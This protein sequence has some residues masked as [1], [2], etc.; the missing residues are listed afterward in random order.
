MIQRHNRR[1]LACF[2]RSLK[3]SLSLSV[4]AG[5]AS[6]AGAKPAAGAAAATGEASIQLIRFGDLKPEGTKL[7]TCWDALGIDDRQRVYVAFSDQNDQAPDDTVI[8]RYDSRSGARELLGTLRQVSRSE[9]NLREGETIAKSHV[10][11]R[12]YN[13]KL[14]F[15]SHDYHSYKD[16][17]NIL[18]RRGGHFYA[19]DLATDT[20]EDL[21]KSDPD[22]VSVQHQGII[23][24]AVLPQHGRLVG[25]TFPFGDLLTYDL[26]RRRATYYEGV[27]E[28][29]ESGKPSRQIIGTSKGKVY[30]SYYDRRSAPIYVFDVDTGEI[31]KTENHYRFGM[32]Y[33][34]LPTRDGRKVYVV[35]LFGNLYAFHVDREWLEELGSLLPP[36][37]V[38]KGVEVTICYAVALSRDEKKL[39]TFPSTF[40][41][42]P[43]L[44][45]YEHDLETGRKRQVADFA[46]VLDGSTT[47]KG[48]GDR[49]GRISGGV[50]DEQGRMYFG[51][52]EG[53]DEGRN[54]VLL[55]VSLTEKR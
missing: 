6:Y 9:G 31:R 38:E 27:A 18:T 23:G 53:G 36:E 24:L 11:F 43:A 50:V 22:G 12:E 46:P 7:T 44:R 45:L 1:A 4:V 19:F 26:E 13:G 15:A 29:R 52:H 37:Q 32:V 10:P 8:F 3:F 25:F 42:G 30:F 54:A 16:R 5:C 14:Y 35:D 40:G 17:K 51:Y 21:S 47:G 2:L 41:S 20:F 39:Y 28:H 55:Q 48:A 33:G 49:K 34:A